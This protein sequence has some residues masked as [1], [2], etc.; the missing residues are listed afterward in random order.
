MSNHSYT[1]FSP[2]NTWIDYSNRE[3]IKN[4][5]N[6]SILQ[7]SLAGFKKNEIDV[8]VS[9]ED[10]LRV[11]ANSQEYGLFEKEYYLNS[12]HDIANIKCTFQ[13]G[14][15]KIVVPIDQKLNKR[16]IHVE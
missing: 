9:D 6:E 1:Y 16:T 3:K 8:F 15:L 12:K 13:D 5:K 11:S 7:I 10:T 2:E 4:S 14:I